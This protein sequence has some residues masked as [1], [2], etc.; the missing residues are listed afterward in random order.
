MSSWTLSNPRIRINDGPWIGVE[1][2]M[3][4][5][6]VDWDRSEFELIVSW[7]GR[8]YVTVPTY[9]LNDLDR[10]EEFSY[11]VTASQGDIIWDGHGRGYVG[12]S[13]GLWTDIIP[14]YD[15]EGAIIRFTKRT[16][17]SK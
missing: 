1:K 7:P 16:D 10:K 12:D 9:V 11:D 15:P 8:K 6:E 14:V 17:G 2:I 5:Q 4:T 13:N 3:L